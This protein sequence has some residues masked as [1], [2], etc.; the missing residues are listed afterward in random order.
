M[1]LRR[2]AAVAAGACLLTVAILLIP[3]R[4]SAKA[5]ESLDPGLT[6]GDFL[7]G[8]DTGLYRLEAAPATPGTGPL[9]KTSLLWGGGEVR[10]ILRLPSGWYLLTSVG[11]VYSPDL[12]TFTPRAS[13][14]PVKTYKV[15]LGSS[16]DLV[17]EVQDLKD[18]EA[19]PSNP[20]RLLCCTKDEVFL[21]EDGGLS[22]KSLG[23]PIPTTGLKAL[24]FG[25][26]PGTGEA[27]VWAS[28]P[29]KGLYVRRLSGS[30]TPWAP[31]PAGLALVPGTTHS[32]EIASLAL[33]PQE[34]G[35]GPNP[36]YPLWASNTFIPRLYRYDQAASLF[37]QVWQGGDGEG[38][39]ESL[40]PLPDGAVRFVT[41]AGVRRFDPSTGAVSPDNYAQAG[42]KAAA[43]AQPGL[44]L[45]SLSFP[46]KSG[47]GPEAQKRQASLSELW[48]PVFVDRKPTRAAAEGKNG[49]YLATGFMVRPEPRKKYFDLMK[50]KGLNSVVIDLKDDTGRLRFQPRDPLLQRMGRSSSPLDI[51]AFVA[52]AKAKG[53][54]LV[55][56]VVVFKDQV[57]YAYGGG[58]YAVWDRASQAPWQGYNTVKVKAP[59]PPPP[60]T[61]PPP[62]VSAVPP[63]PQPEIQTVRQPIEEYW[64]DPYSEDVWA[65]NVAI[66]NEIILRGFDE[67][68]F[69]Y[70]R[71]PT[72]GENLDSAS[73]RWREPGMDKESALASFL[74]YA[75]ERIKAPISIDIYGANGWFRSGVRTG[76]DVELLAKYVDVICPMYY[77]SHFEQGFLA[78]APAEERP[79][80]I[81][82]VGTFRTWVIGRKR[83]V[84]RPY[85]QAFYMGVSYDKVYYDLDYVKREVAGVRDSL[86]LGMTFWN[87]AGRYDDVPVLEYSPEGRLTGP[88]KPGPRLG[89]GAAAGKGPGAVPAKVPEPIQG[90]GPSSGILD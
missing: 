86:N 52:E 49:L 41:E 30:K 16:K 32:E 81:Y 62:G 72:D 47:K 60:T 34:A 67:V 65:Y 17:T 44:Q 56:R 12:Q 22:W 13:G 89:P 10:K 33:G 18:L 55:A 6:A 31:G 28:H 9:L 53:I 43:E 80:R 2:A 14:L 45:L 66:A 20:S 85:V 70:I 26:L 48:L 29:I 35:A 78:Q 57:I 82:K 73:F 5:G 40:D 76:Q 46:E 1:N 36:R 42:L 38:T 87:N 69:D 8:Y 71:F 68:Q 59:A 64:V 39:V 3:A 37:R 24:G 25:P 61:L 50:A 23:Q 27:A 19:D 58:K 88:A 77:P 7:A 79:Y 4:A 83:I 75:R 21:T 15:V 74:R 11:V 51:E 63:P 54:Y 90:Q 84:V